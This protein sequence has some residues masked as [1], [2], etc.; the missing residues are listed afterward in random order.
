MDYVRFFLDKQELGTRWINNPLA[1]RE[2][3][4]TED[5]ERRV[6]RERLSSELYRDMMNT[7][8][9]DIT[10]T[11]GRI[12]GPVYP[13]SRHKAETSPMLHSPPTRGHAR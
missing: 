13:N 9:R 2:E 10:W 5:L 3:W 8:C 11:V 7:I 4:E 6:S 1:W 12:Q